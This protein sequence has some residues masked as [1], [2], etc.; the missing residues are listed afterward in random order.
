MPFFKR[1]RHRVEYVA[2]LAV[3]ALIR[4]LPVETASRWS[5][6]GWRLIAP[7]LHR[8][9]RA[10]TNLSLAFPDKSPA[11]I[12][13]IAAGMWDSLG[14]TFAEFFHLD[15][16]V[17]GGRIQFEPPELFEALRERG[18]GAVACSLHMGN[19]EI[20]SQAALPLGLRPVGVYQRIANPFVDRCA[21]AIRAPLYPGGLWQ[22]SRQVARVM[23]RTA[24]DGECAAMLADQR[25]PNGLAAPFFGRP[26]LSTALPATIARAVG[27][28]LYALRVKRIGD[29]RFSIRIEEVA[30]PRTDNRDADIAGATYNLQATLEAMI[31]E[32]PEQWMWAQT[33]WN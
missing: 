30:T 27:V 20:V 5:G 15:E 24:R 1:L 16:I 29:A 11:E 2:F 12:E 14:R 32:A 19:W 17:G 22:K 8:H 13:A 18:G 9:K 23:L 25:D 7:H 4:A 26:A 33:R 3:V 6:T 31:R 21:K 28:P 10:L